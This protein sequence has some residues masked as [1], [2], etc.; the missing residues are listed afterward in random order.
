[1][2]Y[3]LDAGRWDC[4]VC[5]QSCITGGSLEA[6]YLDKHAVVDPDLTTHQAYRCK[7]CGEAVRTKAKL[8][9][10]RL[11]CKAWTIT[12]PREGETREGWLP[13]VMPAVGRIPEKWH[14]YTDGSGPAARMKKWNDETPDEAGW[15]VGV[16]RQIRREYSTRLRRWLWMESRCSSCPGQW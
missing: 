7:K 14:V 3:K 16:L 6:H 12:V 11:E 2:P 1:M 15:G 10:H 8:G 5:Q 4:P 9:D 13:V